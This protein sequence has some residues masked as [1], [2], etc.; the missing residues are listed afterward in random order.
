G[1]SAMAGVGAMLRPI[2]G[3]L[4]LTVQT[5]ALVMV[6]LVVMLFVAF[7]PAIYHRGVLWLVPSRHEAVAR[8][9]LDHLSTAMRWWMVG[10]LTSMVIVGVLTSLGMWAIGMPAPLA[11]GALAGLLSFVP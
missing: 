1:S 9:T 3:A 10:R 11:L 6:S 7:D 2:A 8:Q 4:S 5:G